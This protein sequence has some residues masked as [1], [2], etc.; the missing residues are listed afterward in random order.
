MPET[1]TFE[2]VSFRYR[3]SGPDVLKDFSWSIPGGRTVLLGPNGAGKTTLLALG[4]DALRALRGTVRVG[5]LV[6]G[7]RRHRSAYRRAVGWMPQQIHAVPGLTCR[8]QVAYA[9]WLKGSAQREAWEAAGQALMHVGLGDLANTLTSRLSGGQLRRVGLAQ[10]LVHRAEIMLLDEP[11]V[12]L[13]PAQRAT[14][15][16]TLAALPAP[17]RVVVSTH[18]VD[19]L[20]ELFDTVVVLDG[21][22]IRYQG[23]VADFLDLAPAAVERRGEAAYRQLVSGGQ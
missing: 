15:R 8:E 6:A 1:L 23:A 14:F 17:S 19:D 13:D 7:V 10:V 20:S 11:T 18:Q 2:S 12:G 4:A 16:E 21:G 3:R 22:Q 5:N 9:A